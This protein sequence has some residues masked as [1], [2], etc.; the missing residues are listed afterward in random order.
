MTN[1]RGETKKAPHRPRIE[2]CWFATFGFM[3]N[4]DR[5]P[6]CDG[7]LVRCHLIPKQIIRRAR[8]KVWDDRAWVWACGGPIGNAGHHGMLDTS[9]TLRLPRVAIPDETEE[10]AA[11]L[12][13][14]WW[15][16]RTYGAKDVNA[17][18]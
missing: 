6:P 5:I 11:E 17:N 1:P 4:G 10:F 13:L 3:E 18:T 16:D 8:G 2:I 7:R 14:E 9:K 12:G 15:L